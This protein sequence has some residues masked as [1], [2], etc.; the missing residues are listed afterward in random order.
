M[1]WISVFIQISVLFGDGKVKRRA[2]VH[3]AFRPGPAAVP[4]NDALD[5]RQADARALKLVL[6]VQ[7]LEHAEQFPG[8]LRIET[9]AVVAYEENR[10]PPAA[11]QKLTK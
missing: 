3:R 6:A 10:A 8:I 11:K 5:V 1:I 9:H 2:T 4:V 7:A